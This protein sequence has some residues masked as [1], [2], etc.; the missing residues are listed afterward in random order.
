MKILD[1]NKPS[2]QLISVVL[3]HFVTCLVELFIIFAFFAWS[4][5]KTPAQEIIAIILMLLYISMIYIKANELAIYDNRPYSPTKP[6]Y[7]KPVLWAAVI[8]LITYLLYA[9]FL[10]VWK[11][12]DSIPVG[13]TVLGNFLFVLWTSPFMG[14]MGSAKGEIM[15]YSHIFFVAVPM[16]AS[17]GGYVAG[18]KKF[19][20][21]EK[22]NKFMYKKEK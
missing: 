9:F 7:R 13:T 10:F 18:L 15:W 3:N 1:R 20:L 17:V 2:H 11:S 22:L 12:G 6:D 5:G 16:L 19:Y 8:I 14:I 21:G 4:I